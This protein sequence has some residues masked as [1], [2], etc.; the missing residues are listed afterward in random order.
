MSR[1]KLPLFY[2]FGARPVKFVRTEEGGMDILAFNWDSG[3][4]ERDLSYLSKLFD[5]SPD[6]YEIT[7]EEFKIHVKELLK[8]VK[9]K[10]KK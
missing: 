2:I 10:D 8:K 5:Y 7:E 9:N 1:F 6:N 3:E 4:F